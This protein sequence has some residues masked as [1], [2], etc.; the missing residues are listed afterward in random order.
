MHEALFAAIVFL[1]QIW[2]ALLL[3]A[4]LALLL[5]LVT[6][7]YDLRKVS[8]AFRVVYA[9]I[10]TLAIVMTALLAFSALVNLI[11]MVAEG[12]A[13]TMSQFHPY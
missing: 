13:G 11:I 9:V 8:R 5:H 3:G 12:L 2:P 4:T 7:V 6:R 10:M 1:A